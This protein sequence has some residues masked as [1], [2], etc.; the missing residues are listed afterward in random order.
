[1]HKIK[2]KTREAEAHARD[3]MCAPPKVKKKKKKKAP[4]SAASLP[5][6]LLDPVTLT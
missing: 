1:M 3:Q 2:N 6:S 5:P 4:M